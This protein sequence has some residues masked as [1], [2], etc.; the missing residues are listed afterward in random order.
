MKLEFLK[1]DETWKCRDDDG[2]IQRMWNVYFTIY[3]SSTLQSSYL[4]MEKKTNFIFSNKMHE[5]VH[6]SIHTYSH[7]NH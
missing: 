3:K 4:Q 7:S 2:K 6:C 5:R 1:L